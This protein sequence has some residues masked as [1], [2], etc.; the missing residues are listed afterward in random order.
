MVNSEIINK[1]KY[2]YTTKYQYIKPD[3][4]SDSDTDT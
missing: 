3:T 2:I 1:N 4:E